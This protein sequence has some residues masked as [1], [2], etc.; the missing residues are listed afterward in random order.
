VK[1]RLWIALQ[2]VVG[3][4]VAYFV[5]RSVATNWGEIRS[6]ATRIRLDPGALAAAAGI[7]L[8]SYAVLITA[9]RAVLAGWG[10][11][12]PYPSAARVWCVSNLARYVP[13]KVWQIAGMATLA[14]K[15][16]VSPWAAAGSA[17]IVQLVSIATGAL[18]TGLAAP[19]WKAHPLAVVACGAVAAAAAAVLAWEKG[20]A[21]LARW[22]G[23]MLGRQFQLAPV[24]PG[25]LLLSALV[26]A[27]AWLAQGL[28]LYL[29]SAGLVGPTALG[30][31]AAIGIFT[32][33]ALAGLL[34]VFTPG[35]L[36]VREGVLLLWLTPVMGARRAIIVLVGS[37]LLLTFTELLAAAITFPLRTQSADATS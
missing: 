36:G 22:V 5:I 11:R 30:V 4:V 13:G 18:I 10:E 9:W 2:L 12:L 31:W 14:Q 25:A 6:S 32:G 3:L 27:L 20:T 35:G 7:V 23:A 1:R 37:R 15:A 8:A 19:Q 16:G 28:A 29:C 21:A 17:V 34:A 24:G 33:G 26:T